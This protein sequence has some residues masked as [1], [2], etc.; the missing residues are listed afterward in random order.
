MY[1]TQQQQPVQDSKRDIPL[2]IEELMKRSDLSPD[3]REALHW[4][5]IMTLA[6]VSPHS[7]LVSWRRK[8]AEP[9]EPIILPE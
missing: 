9:P 2:K 1:P 8:V 3:E 7:A 6:G 4:M 5:Y